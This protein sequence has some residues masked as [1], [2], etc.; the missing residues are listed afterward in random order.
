ML[1]DAIHRR[2]IENAT[3]GRLTFVGDRV[4]SVGRRGPRVAADVEPVEVES[5]DE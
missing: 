3:D 2:L 5:D 4:V 1:L